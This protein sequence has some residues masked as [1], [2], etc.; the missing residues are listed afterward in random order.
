MEK[1]IKKNEVKKEQLL[2]VSNR[3][4]LSVTGVEKIIS[5]KPDLIQLETNFGGLVI[6]GNNLELVKL[7]N[8]TTR[9]EINGKI[10]GL[11]YLDD[12]IKE[13]FFRKLFK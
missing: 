2:V 8:S 12:K 1:E 5:L 4:N 6:N 11:R 7:D 10:I 3:Q 13:P 9:A